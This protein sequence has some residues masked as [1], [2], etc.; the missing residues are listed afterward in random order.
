MSGNANSGRRSNHT[1]KT[2]DRLWKALQK[3]YG[4]KFEP[5]L[6][7]AEIGMDDKNDVE[8]RLRAW[9]EIAP[10]LYPKLKQVEVTGNEDNPLRTKVVLEVVDP[11]TTGV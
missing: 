3:E 11:N 10:Y 4:E 8:T 7:M 6:K 9:K 5:I 1:N 2:K